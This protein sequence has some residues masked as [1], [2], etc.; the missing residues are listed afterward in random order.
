VRGTEALEQR[1]LA[2]LKELDRAGLRRQLRAPSGIDFSSNDYLGLASHPLLKRRMTEAIE[3]LGC[4]STG[5]RLL[6]GERANTSA[7]EQRFAKF[8]NTDRALYFSSGYMANIA[9]LSVFPEDGDVIFSDASNHASLIDG[10]RLSRARKVIFPHNDAGALSQRMEEETRPGQK[11][12]VTESLFSM[13]GD[14]APLAEYA[15]L[16]R[17]HQAALIVDESHAVGI[18]GDRGS[19]LIEECGI[20]HG[21]LA[22]INTAGKALGVAGA[23]VAG[24]EWAIESLVQNARSFIFSTAAPPALA[25]ALD[26]SLDVIA[27]EPQ[28]RNRLLQLAAQ[29]RA[30]LRIPGRSQII[31]MILGANEHATAV[32]SMLQER[33]FD[34]RAIRPPTVP[35][36]TARLRISVNI[37]LSEDVLDRLAAALEE[38]SCAESS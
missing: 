14:F 38:I 23:F 12:V 21:V 30:K 37:N 28:R 3:E 7:V 11:F 27:D 4:G 29:L 20:E 34:V 13:D 16:C 1:L 33:G 8:K 31:P 36:G 17:K 10:M 19:G 15:E 5:S 2:G 9:V 18:Y 35:E 22:S 24:P 25:A 6:R 32:A 26:A